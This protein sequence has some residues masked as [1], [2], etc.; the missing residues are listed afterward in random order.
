MSWGFWQTFMSWGMALFMAFGMVPAIFPAL[1]PDLT[2]GAFLFAMA[3]FR[4]FAIFF[5]AASRFTCNLLAEAFCVAHPACS[6]RPHTYKDTSFSGIVQRIPKAALGGAAR[7]GHQG[8][9]SAS[10]STTPP[11]WRR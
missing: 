5:P 7:V 9:S 2:A 8:A 3:G 11:Y 6:S 10:S 1:L 4:V